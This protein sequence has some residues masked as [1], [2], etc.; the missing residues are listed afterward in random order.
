MEW[1]SRQMRGNPFGKHM[2]WASV[3]M[4]VNVVV[5]DQ[6]VTKMQRKL[7]KCVILPPNFQGLG[8]FL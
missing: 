7:R 4:L 5:E 8:S 1:G 6:N 3:P 2:Y